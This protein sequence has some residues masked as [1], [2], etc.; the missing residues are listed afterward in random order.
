M[1]KPMHPML[2]H[3]PIALLVAS[4]RADAVHSS[5]LGPAS[6]SRMLDVGIRFGCWHIHRV[7]GGDRARAK[8][9]CR[10]RQSKFSHLACWAICYSR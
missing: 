2:V 9:C 6:S 10:P 8:P 5:H 4:F 1:K 7:G 3:F